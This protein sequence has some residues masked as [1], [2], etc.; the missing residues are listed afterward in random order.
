VT[1]PVEP[2]EW[3]RIKWGR[4]P[5][6]FGEDTGYN[7]VWIQDPAYPN[8]PTKQILT[9]P[10]MLVN[11]AHPAFLMTLDMGRGPLPDEIIACWANF[12]LTVDVVSY[13]VSLTQGFVLTR[14][15]HDLSSDRIEVS[16]GFGS[17]LA[18]LPEH[19]G[20]RSFYDE[21]RHY[22]T[23]VGRDL[24]PYRYLSVRVAAQSSGVNS[25]GTYQNPYMKVDRDYGSAGF[26]LLS[27][28]YA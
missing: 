13:A 19:H 3:K 21:F 22:Q 12:Q 20:A 5:V 8:D 15:P 14:D 16:E 17:N 9:L 27:P 2:I 25:V 10:I 26:S 7:F 4:T 23:Y 1:A 6:D 24:T 18:K 28:V 11:E